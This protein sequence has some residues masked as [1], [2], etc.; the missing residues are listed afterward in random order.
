MKKPIAVA[1]LFALS[2]VPLAAQ[3]VVYQ[4]NATLSAA[5]ELHPVSS[6]ANGVATLFYDTATNTYDFAMS[7]FNLTAQASAYHIHGQANTMQT[8]P[9]RVALDAPPFVAFA[10]GGTLLVG[11]SDVAAP[12]GNIPGGNGHP[13]QTF[14]EALQAGL[15]YVNVHT[16]NNPMGEVRGQLFQVAVVPEPG[17]YALMLAGVGA[18]GAF[19]RRRRQQA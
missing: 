6:P 17:T 18:I 19:V 14:L 13:A 11:G 9:V 2:A 3:A 12:G 16:P 7:V 10:N 8:A 5:N 15:M 1:A 4:F